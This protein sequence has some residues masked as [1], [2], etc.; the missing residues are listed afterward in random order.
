MFKTGSSSLP[1]STRATTNLE[2]K[3]TSPNLANLILIF[4]N[5]EEETW[6]YLDLTSSSTL[7]SWMYLNRTP[8]VGAWSNYP[9]AWLEHLQENL[10]FSLLC[11][12]SENGEKWEIWGSFVLKPPPWVWK[13]LTSGERNFK[14]IFS[15][16]A[17]KWLK[18]CRNISYCSLLLKI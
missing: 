14:K 15:S 9:L 3:T 10:N 16:R 18:T 7:P 6:T 1:S 2:P 13:M 17:F 12:Y 4:L 11:S 8:L 5:K